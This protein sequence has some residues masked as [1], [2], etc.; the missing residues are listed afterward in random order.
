MVVESLILRSMDRGP[1]NGGGDSMSISPFDKGLPVCISVWLLLTSRQPCWLTGTKLFFLFCQ[2]TGPSCLEFAKKEI[3]FVFVGHVHVAAAWKRSHQW[4][5]SLTQTI[6]KQLEEWHV[7]VSCD[8]LLLGAA[9]TLLVFVAV[10][11][12]FNQSRYHLLLL[13]LYLHSSL[14]LYSNSL[15][16]RLVLTSF[17]VTGPGRCSLVIQDDNHDWNDWGWLCMITRGNWDD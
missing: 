12:C 7:F 6:P 11:V 9:P 13:Y 4:C 8:Q 2:P 17:Q 10:T 5:I 16:L 15:F 14:D 3:A 1:F